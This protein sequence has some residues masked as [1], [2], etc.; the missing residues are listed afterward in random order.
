MEKGWTIV[1]ERC[2]LRKCRASPNGHQMKVSVSLLMWCA[3]GVTIFTPT[4]RADVVY[5]S[6]W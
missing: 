1:E 4:T 3:A 6:C 2:Q 5:L